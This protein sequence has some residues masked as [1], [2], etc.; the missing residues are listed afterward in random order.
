[1]VI[2]FEVKIDERKSATV[3]IEQGGTIE[4]EIKGSTYSADLP[5]GGCE[6]LNQIKLRGSLSRMKN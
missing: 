1:M 6:V 5:Q 2:G 4:C 3:F